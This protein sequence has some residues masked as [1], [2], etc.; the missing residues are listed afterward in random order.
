M[1]INSLRMQK[2]LEDAWASDNEE[3]EYIAI[4]LDTS[5]ATK[6]FEKVLAGNV[7]ILDVFKRLTLKTC[8]CV[9]LTCQPDTADVSPTSQL[10]MVFFSCHIMSC[11][12]VDCRHVGNATTS[13]R[14]RGATSEAAVR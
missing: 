6:A 3:P 12:V 5:Y 13:Q 14:G 9:I 8:L 10:L 7:N 4:T 1:M 11:P 2:R